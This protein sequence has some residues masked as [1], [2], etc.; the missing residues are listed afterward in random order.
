M[1]LKAI[2]A[3]LVVPVVAFADSDRQWVEASSGR[4]LEG[5]IIKK[6]VDSKEPEITIS[7]GKP[8]KG[9][10]IIKLDPRRLSDDCQ[11]YVHKWLNYQ[12]RAILEIRHDHYL[13]IAAKRSADPYQIDFMPKL[14]GNP[15][16]FK[17]EEWVS[18]K[19][20]P[21]FRIVGIG[22]HAKTFTVKLYSE[23]GICLLTLDSSDL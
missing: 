14:G 6:V 5:K 4:S 7:S 16:R 19:A 22:P 9:K 21:T 11:K 17:V 10:K 2:F 18:E 23:D 13:Y 1:I 20:D 3:A 15:K 12:D 8:G